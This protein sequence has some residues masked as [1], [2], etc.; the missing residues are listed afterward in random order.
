[1]SIN[2]DEFARMIADSTRREILRNLCCAWLSVG[3]VVERLD[4]RVNQPTVSHHLKKM[5]AAGLVNVRSEGRYRYYS[6]NQPYFHESYTA[7]LTEIDTIYTVNF[8][9]VNNITDG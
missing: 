5:A 2:V 7:L 3:D 1:M 4:G 8:V 6:L 9:P